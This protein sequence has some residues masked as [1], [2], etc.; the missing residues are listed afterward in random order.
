MDHPIILGAVA[1]YLF[2]GLMVSA[3]GLSDWLEEPPDPNC[4]WW[5]VLRA[6]AFTM[7][8]SQFCFAWW[9]VKEGGG[10]CWKKLLNILKPKEKP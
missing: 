10:W 7:F 9:T 4:R 5:Q 8:V 6:F 3:M 1:A 2:F